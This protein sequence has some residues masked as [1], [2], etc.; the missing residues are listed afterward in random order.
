MSNEKKVKESKQE[1]KK[2]A[3]S[4]NQAL[5]E[6]IE[7]LEKK[8]DDVTTNKFS[9]QE[10]D[11]IEQAR[12]DML[13]NESEG[14]LYIDPKYLEEGYTYR[15]VDT[16]RPNRVQRMLRRGYEIVYTDPNAK[17]GDNTVTN[18]GSLTGALTVNLGG[19]ERDRL[20]V[21]MRI[22]TERYN[23]LQKIK[24][25]ETEERMG[26]AI[27]QASSGAAFGEITIGDKTHFK[28]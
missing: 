16:T 4:I 12:E 11:A 27:N 5:L 10:Q 17:V 1:Q 15:K 28:K 22:P 26:A 14:P 8:L 18:T 24:E 23:L 25:R 21:V 19:E 2:D 6:K 7:A 9:K 3:V 20:G 13:T